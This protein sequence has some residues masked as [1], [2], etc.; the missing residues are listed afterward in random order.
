MTFQNSRLIELVFCGNSREKANISV[1]FSK[2]LEKDT[3]TKNV[4]THLTKA[5]IFQNSFF[6]F[7]NCA[8]S[9]VM[10]SSIHG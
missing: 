9:S 4:K 6:L 3:N 8:Y 2:I 1:Q 5:V 10:K 7:Y